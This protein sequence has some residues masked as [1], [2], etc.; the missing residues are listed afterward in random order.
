[1]RVVTGESVHSSR[2]RW[3][4]TAAE[5]RRFLSGDS[6]RPTGT[7]PIVYEAPAHV[8]MIEFR[9]DQCLHAFQR[10]DN[11]VARRIILE[12]TEKCAVLASEALANWSAPWPVVSA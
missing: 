10:I 4:N 12:G 7:R 2:R 6:R 8:R 1:M 11:D 5:Q 3:E 9:W